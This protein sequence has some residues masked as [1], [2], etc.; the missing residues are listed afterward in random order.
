VA[1]EGVRLRP[2][3]AQD[4]VPALE[5]HRELA[6]EGFEFALGY[7]AGMRW[8][9][10]L[11]HLEAERIGLVLRAGRVPST[12]LAA[13]VSGELVG[14]ISVRHALND[15]LAHEGGHI[16]FAVRPGYRRRGYASAMLRRGLVVA[17]AVGI[18]RVLV[19]C[20]DANVGSAAVIEACGGGFESA[21][22]GRRGQRVRRYWF[23]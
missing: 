14:R 5:A 10:Y 2:L 23:D 18:D 1:S 4:E 7:A 16:G 22:V 11:N 12:F 6:S 20:D 21:V 8:D 13:D 9:A 19:T 17:R 15:F 3:T